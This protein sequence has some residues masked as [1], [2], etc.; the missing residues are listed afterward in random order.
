MGMWA[1]LREPFG[2]AALGVCLT[3]ISLS[4]A[5]GGAPDASFTP[6]VNSGPAPLSVQFS[7]VTAK[8]GLE[9]RWDFGDAQSST[10][11]A[12]SHTY[13]DVGDFTVTL[14][15]LKGSKTAATSRAQV[16]VEPGPAGWVAVTPAI[17]EVT[18]GDKVQ[19]KAEAFDELGNR[20][21]DAIV[22]WAADPDAGEI[23]PEGAF[24]ARL[25]TGT[26][27]GGVT[28][29]F[30]RQGKTGLG[31]ASLTFKAGAPV[32]VRVEPEKLE[33]VAGGRVTFTATAVDENGTPVTGGQVKFEALRANDRIDDT[34]LFRAGTE[35]TAGDVPLVSVTVLIGGRTLEKVIRATV[36]PGVLDSV[37]FESEFYVV[38]IKESVKLAAMGQDRFGNLIELDEV[39]WTLLNNEPG[40]V[41]EDGTFTAGTKAG[42]FS[43]NYLVAQGSKSRVTASA[44]VQLYITP[45]PAVSLDIDPKSDTVPTGAGSPFYAVI[46]DEYG[47]LISEEGVVWEATAGGTV[48]ETGV[49]VA[50][51]QTGDF[52]G[53]LLA[54]LPSGAL[55]NSSTLT[56]TVSVSVRQRSADTIAVEA[57]DG[58]GGGLALIDLR[59]ANL[60]SPQDTLA[61]NEM[62]EFLPRWTS[63][64]SK[65]VYSAAGDGKPQIFDVDFT[66]KA[67]RQLTDDPDGAVMGVVSPDGKKLAFASMATD[68]WQIYVADISSFS[69]GGPGTPASSK[70]ATR[71]SKDDT[72]RHILPM[73]SPDGAS[74]YYSADDGEGNLVIM[75]AAA[76]G[77]SEKTLSPVGATELAF[78]LSKDGKR[79]LAGNELEDGSVELVIIDIATAL[80]TK[81]VALPFTVFHAAWSPDESEVAVV[82]GEVGAMWIVDS[83]GTGLRQVLSSDVEPRRMAWRPVPLQPPAPPPQT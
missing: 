44:S 17:V 6:S 25:G 31:A 42:D 63:D 80:R 59:N 36:Q 83:D 39:T 15:L 28:A 58:D 40:E 78:S 41:K 4:A 61:Q 55:G 1:V 32:A 46:K 7:P 68:E 81:A 33:I 30:E 14:T 53:A 52:P 2:A 26:Y 74:L 18:A 60:R 19:F 45:G 8:G 76:D 67:I 65:L 16:R 27:G 9:Y 72:K 66:T 75:T 29:S 56:A 34:G 51:M 23:T 12:P 37:I 43:E 49:F 21:A 48:S 5:C 50:G 77:S 22:S 82:D 79:L 70:Q 13:Q 71:I 69:S 3:L 38:S 62:Q 54:T 73:W 10:D 47:N 11:Q 24:T 64:G 20:V 35:A 57:L